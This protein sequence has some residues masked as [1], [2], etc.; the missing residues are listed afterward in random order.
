MEFLIVARLQICPK[1]YRQYVLKGSQVNTFRTHKNIKKNRITLLHFPLKFN[2]K[3]TLT[4]P[5]R[6]F[7]SSHF[8]FDCLKKSS[9]CSTASLNDR[10]N[11]G[12]RIYMKSLINFYFYQFLFSFFFLAYW[13]AANS[14]HVLIR[15]RYLFWPLDPQTVASEKSVESEERLCCWD[16]LCDNMVRSKSELSLETRV[17]RIFDYLQKDA[18]SIFCFAKVS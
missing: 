12:S 9:F 6:T 7:F 15:S 4:F 10:L 2:H 5:S 17:Q 18:N 16:F 14:A 8:K 1:N 13:T 11:D 3:K